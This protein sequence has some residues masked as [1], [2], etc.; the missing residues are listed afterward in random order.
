MGSRDHFE[1]TGCAVSGTADE[2]PGGRKQ[3]GWENRPQTEP[4]LLDELAG[5][6][7]L[8]YLSDLRW[9]SGPEKGYLRHVLEEYDPRRLGRGAQ[10][11]LR[12]WNDALEYLASLPPARERGEAYQRLTTW[13]GTESTG[14]V[15]REIAGSRCSLRA[16][17]HRQNR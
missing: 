12:Q 14:P 3:P 9:L 10:I 7:G 4:D 13:A 16:D 2:I 17:R 6:L 5:R 15:P 11:S 1:K 8:M